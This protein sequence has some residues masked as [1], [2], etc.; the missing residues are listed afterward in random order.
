M[1][2]QCRGNVELRQR[3]DVLWAER[4]D[5]LKSQEMSVDLRE[6]AESVDVRSP[7][8][9]FL[10]QP[11]LDSKR[12]LGQENTAAYQPSLR[13]GVAIN[14]RYVLQKKIGEGGMGEVWIAQQSQPV[15]RTVALKLIKAGFDSQGVLQRFE[16][17]RQALAMMDHPHIAKVLDAGLTDSG[18]PFFVMELIKGQPLTAYCDQLKLSPRAVGVVR[19]NL[20]RGSTCSSKGD[21]APRSQASEHFGDDG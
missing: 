14:S 13:P 2:D 20:Q 3:V 4:Q 11:T 10:L 18:L 21:R 19:A 16:Q 7:D 9:Q 12:S 17:E 8:S 5:A 6:T 15:K 1:A